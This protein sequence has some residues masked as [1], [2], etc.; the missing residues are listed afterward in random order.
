MKVAFGVAWKFALIWVGS[1]AGM[2]APAEAKCTRRVADPL[3]VARYQQCNP[4]KMIS[5]LHN[6][7]VTPYNFQCAK[8]IQET[9]VQE[10]CAKP[11]N[12][13]ELARCQ[14]RYVAI[15]SSC[16]DEIDGAA[17]MAMCKDSGAWTVAAIGP[18]RKPTSIA[19]TTPKIAAAAEPPRNTVVTGTPN[20]AAMD[21]QPKFTAL[22][23]QPHVS[24][25][26]D[27]NFAAPT[28]AS[29]AP[30]APAIGLDPPPGAARP[31]AAPEMAATREEAPV[32]ALV[33]RN[34][35][36]GGIVLKDFIG[37]Q[38]APK[39]LTRIDSDPSRE[40]DMG[41]AYTLD[42]P[43][44]SRMVVPA[45]A[46]HPDPIPPALPTVTKSQERSKAPP[47]REYTIEMKTETYFDME[48]GDMYA[49]RK[50]IR[51]YKRGPAPR[52]NRR[53]AN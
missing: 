43:P 3:V 52:P 51:R 29:A 18:G 31:S 21:A 35:P 17:K 4:R 12:E 8:A 48:T 47:S 33:L 50:P 45:P 34:V 10:G 44:A 6:N 32:R 27:T 16:Q 23:E 39:P 20:L 14:G 36:S 9:C 13:A 42:P 22:T 7:I 37:P 49:I 26:T 15:L 28:V 30:P 53:R 46:R 24:A 5:Y 25:A 40:E 41:L 11:K 2:I 19:K 38:P 1:F